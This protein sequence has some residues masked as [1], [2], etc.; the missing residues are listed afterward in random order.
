VKRPE[1]IKQNAPPDFH[2]EA[3]LYH[4]DL[5]QI[6]ALFAIWGPIG[7]QKWANKKR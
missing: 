3:L 5:S 1:K 6:L 7:G 4:H 2:P